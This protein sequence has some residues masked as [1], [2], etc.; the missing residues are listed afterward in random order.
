MKPGPVIIALGL[1]GLTLGGGYLVAQ[2]RSRAFEALAIAEAQQQPGKVDQIDKSAKVSEDI[3]AN[4]KQY[5]EAY[6]R[7]D[8]KGILALCTE[9]CVFTDKDGNVIRGQKELE[10]EFK[11]DF[12]DNPKARISLKLDSIR[13][14]TPDVALEQGKM[15]YFPDG[16]IATVETKYEVTH[17]K[18]GN[19]WL[20]AMGRSYDVD[21]LTPYEYLRDLDWLIGDWIDEGADSVVE[22]SYRW[23]DNKAF[24]LQEFTVRA[25][26]KKVLNGSQRI[27]WDPLSKQIKAWIF[28]SEGGHGES[29][30]SNV[31]DSWVIQMRAVRLDGKVATATNRIT[32]IG[33][34]R[35]AYQSVD[36]IVGEEAQPNLAVT[37]VRKPPE[38]KR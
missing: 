15:V 13:M 35:M 20:M 26:G 11:E 22:I 33:T 16:Q 19:R 8:V 5:V 1:I 34:D 7:Q 36:R 6:N 23:T 12:E 24:L 27:G 10:K 9:D 4:A 28:D 21:V 3:L 25:N 14:L 29:Y 31:D 38:S 30:W 2:A 32:R 37:I 18:K 17:V